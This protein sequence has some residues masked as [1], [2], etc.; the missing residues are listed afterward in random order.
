MLINQFKREVLTNQINS[1][2][3]INLSD[4]WLNELEE[5]YDLL[6]IAVEEILAA[7][8]NVFGS[9]SP[10]EIDEYIGIY[11]IEVTVEKI[12]RKTDL[13]IEAATCETILRERHFGVRPAYNKP[14]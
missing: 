2:L 3:P 9:S 11:S 14:H 5:N 12:R 6:K 7:R 4:Y 13:Y 1:L 8:P 10:E